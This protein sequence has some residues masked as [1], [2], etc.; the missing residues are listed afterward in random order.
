M[1]VNQINLE[2][3]QLFVNQSRLDYDLMFTQI[4]I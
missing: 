2:S 4:F 3:V 1:D